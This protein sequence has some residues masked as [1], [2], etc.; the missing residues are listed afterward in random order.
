MSSTA[1]GG[2]RGSSASKK[3]FA[4]AAFEPFHVSQSVDLHEESYND[5]TF[6]NHSLPHQHT[7]S[8]PNFAQDS[9]FFQLN[10]H[11][12]LTNHDHNYCLPPHVSSIKPDP[13]SMPTCSRFI[14]NQPV[15]E[16]IYSDVKFKTPLHPVRKSTVSL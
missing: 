15:S 5:Q 10:N 14:S 1:E 4:S 7:D 12:N 13:D 3:G 6:V 8:L 9:T 2:R 11:T 16:S